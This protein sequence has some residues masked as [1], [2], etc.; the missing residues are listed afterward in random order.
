MAIANL[1]LW[2]L[3]RSILPIT[4]V[5]EHFFDEILNCNC[6]AVW[7]GQETQSWSLSI[8]IISV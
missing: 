7:H 6:L 5:F 2:P 4:R 3:A 1:M 8:D